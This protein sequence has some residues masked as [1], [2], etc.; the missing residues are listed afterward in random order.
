[1]NMDRIRITQPVAEKLKAYHL[2]PTKKTELLSFAYGTI[3]KNEDGNIVVVVANPDDVFLLAPD[4]YISKGFAHLGVHVDVRAGVVSKAIQR[5]QQAIVVIDAHDHFFTD[6]ACF[7]KA[8][9]RDDLR[10]AIQY[11]EQLCHYL[12]PGQELFA[13]SLLIAQKEWAARR[14]IWNTS[15]QPEFKHLVVDILGQQ[16]ERHGLNETPFEPWSVRQSEIMSLTHSAI[17]KS[18]RLTIVGGGGT[19]SIAVEAAARLGFRA[20]DIIDQDKIETSNLNRLHGAS[21]TDVGKQKASFLTER[22]KALFP[23]GSFRAINTDAFSDSATNSL[24]AADIILGCVDNSETRWY[25]NRLAVQFAIPFFDCGNLIQI[26]SVVVF[27]SRVNAIIPG[28][29]PCGHCSDIEFMPRKVPDSFVE[30]GTLKAQ[31]AAG[32]VQNQ[33]TELPAPA[34]Y[35]LNLQ[36]VSW[37]MNEIMNWICGWQPFAHSIYHRSNSTSIE[38]LDRSNYLVSPG[39]DCPICSSLLGTC[40]EN[41]LPCRGVEVSLS[42]VIPDMESNYG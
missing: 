37:L 8:D 24:I 20:I 28:L 40:F 11:K 15:E 36:T 13:V 31:R 35:P 1:M 17:I 12:N 39:E 38:R 7:S 33:S 25:L 19:G 4:C 27:H 9:D 21:E 42:N 2:D 26:D 41:K 22:C 30:L 14:V 18:L 5:E 16:L 3:I 6:K 34:V 29:T 23:D 10:T 32:Y